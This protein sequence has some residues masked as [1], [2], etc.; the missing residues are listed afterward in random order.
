MFA[1]YTAIT[2]FIGLGYI[3][4]GAIYVGIAGI[5]GPTICLM[6]APALKGALQLG[7]P[8]DKL[9]SAAVALLFT[10][11]GAGLTYHSGYGL[12]IWGHHVSGITWCLLGSFVGWISIPLE[13]ARE[14]A[15][16]HMGA[17]P[18]R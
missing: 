15:A 17:L 12:G 6:A 13:V 16:K 1:A 9:E 4:N 2:L 14:S 3:W 10:A 18:D 8:G 7:G 5:A 11:V